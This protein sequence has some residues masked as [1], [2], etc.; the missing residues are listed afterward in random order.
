MAQYD[1]VLELLREVRL[2]TLR[3][4][5][6]LTQSEA[7]MRPKPGEWSVGEVLDHLVI[8]ETLYREMIQR[9]IVLARAGKRPVI[10]QTLRDVNTRIPFV[11]APL[12]P[13]MEIPL[14]VTNMFVPPFVR[15]RIMTIR[16]AKAKAPSIAAPKAAKPLDQLRAELRQSVMETARLLQ[17]NS[18]LD[19]RTMRYRHPVIGNNNVLQILRIVAFHERRHQAQIQEIIRAIGSREGSTLADRVALG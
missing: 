18:D 19:F 14:T 16:F 8:S 10:V 2:D 12:M 9:L 15:E 3:L 7:D 5:E 11:P 13:L 1:S 4:A 17:T 6:P